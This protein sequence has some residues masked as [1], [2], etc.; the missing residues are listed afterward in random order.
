MSSADFWVGPAVAPRTYRLVSLLGGGGEGEVWRAEVA[1]STGGRRQVAVKIL[2]STGH[3]DEVAEWDRFGHLLKSL[4]H[5]GLVRVTDVF[6]GAGPH[7]GDEAARNPAPF[8]YVVMDY[9]D[10]LSLREWCDENPEATASAR[11]R[12]LRMIAS[13]LDAMHAGATTAVP[14]AHS[15]VKPSNIVL[16]GEGGTVLVDLGLARLTDAA[17][18]ADHSAPY[19]APE[20]RAP[21][22]LATP[23]ADRYAFAATTAHVLTGHPPPTG[24]GGWLDLAGLEYLLRSHPITH[25]RPALIKQ[26]LSTLA[27]PPPA[28]PRQLRPWLDAA[29]D[30]LSQITTGAATTPAPAAPASYPPQK[31]SPQPTRSTPVMTH[32]P[33]PTPTPAPRPRR[34]RRRRRTRAGAAAVLILVVLLGGAAGGVYLTR[35]GGPLASLIT[36]GNSASTSQKTTA[37]TTAP[38]NSASDSASSDSAGP[39]A[40]APASSG[41]SNGTQL[42]TYS[43]DLPGGYSAPLGISQ[44]TRSAFNPA[45]GGDIQYNGYAAIFAE[46]NEQIL[47]LGGTP[48]T[49]QGCAADTVIEGQASPKAGTTF[50]IAETGHR[51]A[52]VTVTS[53]GTTQTGSSYVSLDVIIWQNSQP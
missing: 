43:F 14:V 38:T 45:D 50:C 12:M 34:R 20:L 53:V 11:L 6:C 26:I 4:G 10:G 9:I 42:A 35:P 21:G 19:T 1:L 33:P 46:N 30:A 13:A 17:G 27:A 5:P 52:G 44:P 41:A 40:T 7:R 25:R 31:P 24:P 36:T 22:A 29:S 18:V 49:Y 23:E 15:D 32:T 8:R 3:T 28:R 39:A 2:P 16:R 51:M 48:P 37:P 47:D